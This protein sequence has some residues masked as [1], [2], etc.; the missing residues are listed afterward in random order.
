MPLRIPDELW[1]GSEGGVITAWSWKIISKAFSLRKEDRQRASTL[2]ERS[3]VDLRSM[4]TVGGMC[5]L[6]TADIKYLLSDN[7]Y[8]K[9]WSSS[10]LSFALWYYFNFILFDQFTEANL[11]ICF[12]FYSQT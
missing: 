5:L 8:S 1:S 12:C 11:H 6:P 7:F 10:S 2:V 9:V 4:A 3:F